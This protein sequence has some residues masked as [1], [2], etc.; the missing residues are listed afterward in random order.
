MGNV[1]KGKPVSQGD[2]AKVAGVSRMT[3][4]S[5]LR[6]QPGVGEALRGRIQEIATEMGYVPDA[7]FNSRME[8]VR[9][10]KSKELI[11][12]AW[13]NTDPES[14]D[15]WQTYPYLSPYFTGAEARCLELGYRIDQLWTRQAGMTNRRISQI[16]FQRGIRG[17]IIAPPDRVHLGHIRLNWRHFSVATFERGVSA[18]RMSRV[19]QDFYYNTMVALKLLRRFDYRRIGMFISQQTDRRAYYAQQAAIGLFHSRIPKAEQVPPLMHTERDIDGADLE[20]WLRTERPDVVVGQHNR[21]VERVRAAGYRVPE[22]IG[23][24]HT[25]LEDDCVDWAGMW[26]HKREIGAAVAELV[27]SRIQT[28]QPGLPVVPYD[29]M[30]PGRWHPGATLLIPKPKSPRD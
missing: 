7:R 11:P 23:V 13:L 5:A 19:S 2:I 3:V 9:G 29:I 20:T 17:V 10:A 18:P 1:R 4:S 15:C 8:L 26:A 21:L 6:N 12:I 14:R 22:D 24:F 28:H 16:L 25:A 30:I 27:I